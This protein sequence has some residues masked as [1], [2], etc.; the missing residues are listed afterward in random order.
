MP[1]FKGE[2]M[3]ETFLIIAPGS[4]S[5]VQDQG[6]YGYQ[7]L[8]VPV[9]G[10]L[11]TLSSRLGNL[12]VGNP[13]ESAVLEMT[14]TGV[15]LAVLRPTQLAVTGGTA[16][17]K[18]NSKTCPPWHALTVHPGDLVR[19]GQVTKGCR[20]YLAVSG[21]IDVPVVM[22]SRS[23]SVGSGLGGYQGRAI[24]KGDILCTSSPAQERPGISL[25][26]ADI[27]CWKE[28]ITLRCLPGPQD[29][30]FTDIASTLLATAYT[31]TDQADR[32]GLRLQG[33]P[34]THRSSSPGTVLSE[35]SLPGNIQVPGDGQ[36]IVLLKEQTVGGYA[37]VATV[38]S[39]DLYT[40][41]Q[42]VPGD[43]VR[44]QEIS[45]EAAHRIWQDMEDWISALAH[46]L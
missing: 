29:D 17:I 30:L 12:L 39:S 16:E 10:C 22:G 45:L 38:I 26:Q 5:T 32:R 19:I 36:P 9:S 44:F 42:A 15:T 7:A 43:R 21:G 2:P 11:D 20:M 18:I 13:P 27:P 33:P 35:P 28:E 24:R 25:T 4:L 46:T 6:R 41:A 34:V 1:G 3:P 31:L 23:T 40:L 8:G 37:K 14:L